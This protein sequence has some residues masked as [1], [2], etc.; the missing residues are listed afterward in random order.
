LSYDRV[1]LITG[2]SLGIGKLTAALLAGRGFRV[3]GTSRKASGDKVDGVETLQL[4]VTSDKSVTTCVSEV[5]QK[6][7]RI[8]VLVN[9]AGQSCMGGLEETSIEE[10]K[11]Q[12]DSNFFGTVRMV[13]AVLP[14]MRKLRNGQIINIASLAAIF[15]IPFG[16]YYSAAK[17]ALMV[18]SEVLR[19][20][21]KSLGVKVSV[22]EPGF[23]NTYHARVRAANSISDYDDVRQR[24]QS[25]D[26]KSFDRGGDPQEVAETIVKIIETPI[27][28]LHYTVGKEKRYVLL[29]RILPDSIV[30][31]Q[32][33]KHW[34]LNG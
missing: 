4:D 16:G 8:D 15:P 17:S 24:A 10:A 11:A 29:K 2:T 28:R 19:Q 20:E 7:G 27:P 6:T 33:S 34:R 22:V 18:Y 32:T 30:E 23:F 21:L 3:F 9:N 31:S 26:E 5:F 12:F 13:N 14:S 1:V 25:V